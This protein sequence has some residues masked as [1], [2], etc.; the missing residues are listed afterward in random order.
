MEPMLLTPEQ[1]AEVLN[2]GRS[3]IYDLMRVG[4]LKSV[5]IGRSRRIPSSMV[6]EY[7]SR[8]TADNAA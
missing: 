2:V 8:L 6:R 4:L 5:K 3:T 7:V 1:A